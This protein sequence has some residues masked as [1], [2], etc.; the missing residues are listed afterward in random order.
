[1]A[2]VV[3]NSRDFYFNE[4]LVIYQ[5]ISEILAH[6]GAVV[7]DCDAML[8]FDTEASFAQ[9]QRQG[10]LINFFQE[11]RTQRIE[12][13]EG[14]ADDVPRQ[15]LQPLLICVFCVHLLISARKL[16]RDASSKALP[17]CLRTTAAP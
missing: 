2:C 4:K 3:Q 15:L 10:I 17:M 9:F 16:F 13:V 5:Q 6:D 1:M 7:G 11:S 8:L 14:T 12:H